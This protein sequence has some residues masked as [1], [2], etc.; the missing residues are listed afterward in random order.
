M[1]N[2]AVN[3]IR[4]KY[5]KYSELATP[6]I[7]I[8]WFFHKHWIYVINITHPPMKFPLYLKIKVRFALVA[9][10]RLRRHNHSISKTQ[11][12]VAHHIDKTKKY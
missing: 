6:Y 10:L 8:V 12:F 5:C 11:I 9:L 3:S 4:Q 7:K 2:S 1:Q